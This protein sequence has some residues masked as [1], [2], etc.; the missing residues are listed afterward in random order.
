MSGIKSEIFGKL[1]DGR[2]VT[3]Y[4]LSRGSL[5]ATI[6]DLGATVAD[7]SFDGLSLVRGYDSLESYYEADGYLGAVVGRVGNR[8]AGG[9]FRLDGREYSLFCNNGVNHLH[10][11]KNGFDKKLWRAQPHAGDEPSIELSLLS[12]DGDEGYPGNLSVTVLYTLTSRGGLRID[13]TFNTDAPTVANLTNHTYFNLNGKGDI[14]SHTLTLAADRY[15][16]TDNGLIPTG[17]IKSVEGTPFDFRSGKTVGRDIDKPCRDLELAGGYDHCFVFSPV[18]APEDEPRAIL[19][20]D[21]SDREL[22]LYTDRPGVQFY[23]GN[24][25]GNPRFPFRGGVAQSKRAAL[26]LET[27]SA[28]DAVNQ[29]QLDALGTT[30]LRPGVTR[31]SFTEYVIS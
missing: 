11:G 6:L 25:L 16:P 13:Y 18:A 9:S 30:V 23:T 5:T 29:P 12:P 3:A 10:G 14:L 26:C 21:I 7:L 31:H 27:E 4:T 8:I 19:R 28:P 20:G 15:L 1:P 2:A 17:E 24:F 22:R